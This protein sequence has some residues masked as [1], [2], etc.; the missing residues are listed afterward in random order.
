MLPLTNL[1]PD[2]TFNF[3]AEARQTLRVVQACSLAE[4]L[5]NRSY[6]VVPVVRI[7]KL[8]ART[9]P[10]E[11]SVRVK[12]YES[13]MFLFNFLVVFLRQPCTVAPFCRK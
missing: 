10:E 8:P 9:F 4:S 7:L 3:V 13:T 5:H 6:R 1:V 2:V 11:A 12:R